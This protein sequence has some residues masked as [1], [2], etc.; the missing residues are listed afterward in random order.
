VADPSL[1]WDGG[2]SDSGKSSKRAVRGLTSWPRTAF[3]HSQRLLAGWAEWGCNPTNG[4]ITPSLV[5]MG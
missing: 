1:C 3:Q 2:N 5:V 4:Y